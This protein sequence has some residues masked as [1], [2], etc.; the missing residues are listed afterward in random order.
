MKIGRAVVCIV[1]WESW[2]G[3]GVER[4]GGLIDVNGGLSIET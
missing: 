4:F 1:G 3:L 2:L